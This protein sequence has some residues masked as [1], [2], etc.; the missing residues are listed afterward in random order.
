MTEHI[1]EPVTRSATG[2]RTTA[3]P[4]RSAPATGRMAL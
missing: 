4:L 3:V 1:P 2:A